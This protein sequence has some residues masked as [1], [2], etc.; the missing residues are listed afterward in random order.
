VT[1]YLGSVRDYYQQLPA[2]RF[3]LVTSMAEI[4]TGDGD[5]RFEF[6]LDLLIAGLA[7]RLP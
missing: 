7:A 3:P 6:G 1:E 5:Q 4:I 2:E